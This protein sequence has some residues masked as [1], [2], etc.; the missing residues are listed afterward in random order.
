VGGGVRVRPAKPQ[1]FTALYKS[2][3]EAIPNTPGVKFMTLQGTTGDV[4][5][6][7]AA[8][9]LP[10]YN[11]NRGTFEHFDE[12]AGERM[13]DTILVK[14]DTCFA[15][16]VRCKPVLATE[17]KGRK[18]LP[19]HGGIEY[20]TMAALGSYCGVHD[21]NAIALANQLCN[22]Y[23][24]DTITCG[25]TIA[26]VMECFE[27]GL[28]S[29]Q[30]TGGLDLHFGNADSMLQ[31]VEMI[32]QR[33]GFGEELGEGSERMAKVIGRGAEQ[34]LTTSKGQEA[35]AHMPQWKRMMGL[36]YAVNPFGADHMSSEHD[37]FI[38]VG[39]DAMATRNMAQLG[40]TEFQTPGSITPYKAKMVAA[41]QKIYSAADTYCLCSFVWGVGWQ[42]YSPEQIAE[43]LSYATGWDVTLEEV[44]RVGE[45][46]INMMRAF[47]MREGF[48]RSNDT[49]PSKFYKPLEGPGPNTS[50]HYEPAEFEHLLDDYYRAME[51]DPRTGNPTPEKLAALGLDWVKV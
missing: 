7:N 3:T 37:P 24:M 20:E 45:R 36:I 25:A 50:V 51:W 31:L 49:I 22:L 18:V 44:L 46:R 27:H 6:N 35:P 48:D 19:R 32:G 2:G 8:G 14:R 21:M 33:R 12:I 1:E 41:T 38:E 39:A 30:Q 34:Y 43:M 15:C 9:A 5:G 10:T 16:A 26:F 47:N 40:L 11:F 13:T 28:L 29:S 23:G 42:L 17:Y 4:A